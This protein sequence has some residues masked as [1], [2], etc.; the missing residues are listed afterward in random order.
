L[1][2]N[3][4]KIIDFLNGFSLE[5]LPSDVVNEAKRAVLDTLGCM[6][7]GIDTP[8]GKNLRELAKRYTDK[9]GVKV[10]GLKPTVTPIMAAMCNGYMANA[11]DAD[12]GHRRSRLHA[13]GIIIPTALAAGEENR[14]TGRAFLESVIIG[15][16]LGHRAGM[17]TTAMDTYYGSAM[18]G[19]FGAAAAGWLMRLSPD[20]IVNAMGIAEMHAPNCMLMGWIKARKPPMVKEGMGWSA[21]SG[22]MSAYMSQSGITGALTL[23][24]GKEEISEIDKMGREWETQRRYYKLYPGCRWTQAPL[25]TLQALMSEHDVCDK[26]AKEIKVRIMTNASNLDNP[27]PENMEE[28]QYSIPFVL[29]ATLVDGEFGPEQMR[30]EKLTNPAI[31]ELAKKVKVEA[32][33]EFDKVYPRQIRCEVLFLTEKGE[34]LLQPPKRLKG[35]MIFPLLMRK[36][37]KNLSGSAATD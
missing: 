37:K 34:I 23:Y 2:Q 33:P 30:M 26:D 24:N 19:T 15:F 36:S 25:Q 31:L 32:E 27:A 14:S 29:A 13:G 10:L 17:A 18:G 4:E 12:D 28:A 22:L 35:T 7:A 21:A 8:L 3:Q 20:L 9:Q 11:H 1:S 16:E 6:I 5:N